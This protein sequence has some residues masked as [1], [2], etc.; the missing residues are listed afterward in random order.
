MRT[1]GFLIQKEFIQIFRNRTLLPIIFV[2]PLVQLILLLYAATLEMKG[3]DMYIVD[4]DLSISSRR[5]TQKFQSSPFYQVKDFSFSVDQAEEELKNG[6]ADIVLVIPSEFEQN[7]FRKESPKVQFLIDAINGTAAGLI[8]AYTTAI[9]NGFSKEMIPE[10]ASPGD[11]SPLSL[12]INYSL[13]YNPQMNYKIYMLPAL[14][15]ILV[16]I[17]GMFLSALNMVREKELGTIEQINVTPIRK[18]HFIIGKLIPFW[19][20]ALVELGVLLVVGKIFFHLPTI[21]SIGLLYL[22]ASL[23]LL[24]VMGVSLFMSTISQNQQQVMFMAFFFVIIFVMMGGIFTP[25]ETMPDWAQKINMI[26]PI[27]Y[28]IRVVRM[29]LLKG[30]TITDILPELKSLLVYSVIIISLAVWRYRKTT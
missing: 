4:Q 1:I 6:N 26:N 19:F 2:A 27:A 10:I 13:W 18:H 23:Y 14:M 21:G 9:I 22:F 12:N 20:I 7:L 29:I 16:T 3:I 17:I 8:N 11:R 5:L 24:A 28:F 25:V 15:V 30:S